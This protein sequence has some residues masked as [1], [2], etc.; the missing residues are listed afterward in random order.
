MNELKVTFYIDGEESHHDIYGTPATPTVP[1]HLPLLGDI[2][3]HNSL[4]FTVLYR[5]WRHSEALDIHLMQSPE[6]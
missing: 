2:V 3:M 1:H 6:V 5:L 4:Y